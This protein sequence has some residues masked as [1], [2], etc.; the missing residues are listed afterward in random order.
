MALCAA[1]TAGAYFLCV[2]PLVEK[3][4]A[5]E[6]RRAVV[7]DERRKADALTAAVRGARRELDD[8]RSET[9]ATSVTLQSSALLNQRMADL[10]AFCGKTGMVVRDI[11]SMPEMA[12]GRYGA[13]PITLSA[14]GRYQDC[15][16]ML[17][18]LHK[19]FSDTGVESFEMLAGATERPAERTLTARLVWYVAA[20]GP[21]G[22]EGAR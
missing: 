8:T 15:A 22:E 21:R 13:V 12:A 18:Q 1:V 16:R 2:T 19:K 7:A 5:A 4:H 20:R 11:Q 14:T 6:E 10:A 3:R 9:A 17:Q